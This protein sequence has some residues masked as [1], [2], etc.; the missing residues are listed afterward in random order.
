M[1]NDRNRR[2]GIDDYSGADPGRPRDLNEEPVRGTDDEIRG[3]SDEI[4]EELEDTD[5]LEDDEDSDSSF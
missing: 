5:D 2:E 1:A 4:D 3:I